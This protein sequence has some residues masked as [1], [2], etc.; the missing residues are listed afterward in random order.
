MSANLVNIIFGMKMRQARTEANMTL[1]EFAAA[2][3]LS[4]SYVTEI[5]KGR[6][7]PRSDKIMKIAEVLGRSYDDLVS[8]RLDNSLAHLETTLA[9]ATFQRFPFEEFGLEPGD[10]VTLLTREP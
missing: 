2:C 10:L 1:T 8:I 4:P 3:D 7:Y 5:E 9:S 6:K